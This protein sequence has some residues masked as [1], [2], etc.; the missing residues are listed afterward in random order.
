MIAATG[1]AVTH[2]MFG[3]GGGVLSG[4]LLGPGRWVPGATA[5]TLT[6]LV[7][8][9]YSLADLR[10]TWVVPPSASSV[11]WWRSRPLRR[12]ACRWWR[13]CSRGWTAEHG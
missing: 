12:S 6:V 11:R 10:R 7:L 5:S 8:T 4:G 3:S 2:L 9:M 13:S 1:L